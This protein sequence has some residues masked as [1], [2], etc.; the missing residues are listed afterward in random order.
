M[1]KARSILKLN[2][3]KLILRMEKE[4]S[5]DGKRMSVAFGNNCPALRVGFN[6]Q[7]Q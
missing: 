7:R 6:A 4:Q 5:G 1:A 2:G 3:L